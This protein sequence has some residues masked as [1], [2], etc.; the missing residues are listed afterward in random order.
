MRGL[1]IAAPLG[2]LMWGGLG[3]AAW[4]V[5]AFENLLRGM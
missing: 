1:L 3:W 5:G 2:L 4:Y